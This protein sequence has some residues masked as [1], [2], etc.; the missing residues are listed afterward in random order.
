MQAYKQTCS[1]GKNTVCISPSGFKSA[2]I[3]PFRQFFFSFFKC[4]N[5]ILIKR[6]NFWLVVKSYQLSAFF[7]SSFA[8]NDCRWN[9][10]FFLTS[11]Q[12]AG[13]IQEITFK[14]KIWEGENQVS[15]SDFHFLSWYIYFI[16]MPY[17]FFFLQ[18]T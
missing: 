13:K 12:S 15:R 14:K 5:S 3:F 4:F 7:F 18:S 2:E 10:T 6:E 9:R 11:K 16:W 17:L 8:R 1:D